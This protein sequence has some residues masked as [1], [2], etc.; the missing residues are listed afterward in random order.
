MAKRGIVS[1]TTE[2]EVYP[3]SDTR[4]LL[5]SVPAEVLDALQRPTH[6]YLVVRDCFGNLIHHGRVAIV[7]GPEVE[8]KN[9]TE[10]I[11]S[12]QLYPGQVIRLEVARV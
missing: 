7:S 11:K 10:Q 2:V 5:F 6:V 3:S 12:G 8:K 9:F 4:G 1:I